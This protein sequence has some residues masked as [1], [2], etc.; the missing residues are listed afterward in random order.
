M[1]T[2]MA[3]KLHDKIEE[4]TTDDHSI[5]VALRPQGGATSSLIIFP[6]DQGE[7]SLHGRLDILAMARAYGA[8]FYISVMG[9][10][11]VIIID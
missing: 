8:E 2:E 10:M 1:K 9:D 5:S 4:M 6:T 3:M 7:K 11:P